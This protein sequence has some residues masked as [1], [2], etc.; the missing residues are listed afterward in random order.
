MG[1]LVRRPRTDELWDRGDCLSAALRHLV[2]GFLVRREGRSLCYRQRLRPFL[3]PLFTGVR[4]ETVW[5]IAEGLSTALLGRQEMPDR[6]LIDPSWPLSEHSFGTYP[7]F[8]NSFGRE[9]LGSST[10]RGVLYLCSGNKREESAACTVFSM[11]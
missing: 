2:I 5:K 9:I 8:P 7:E 1:G 6:G 3:L 10:T 11:G 4:G